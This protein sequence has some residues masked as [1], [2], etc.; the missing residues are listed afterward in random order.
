MAVAG[1]DGLE[2][3]GDRL[4]LVAARAIVG[5]ELVGHSWQYAPCR[6]R[7][8]APRCAISCSRDSG[9][10]SYEIEALPGRRVAALVFVPSA[11]SADTFYVANFGINTIT[12]YD[13]NGERLAVHERIRQWP[14]RPRARL[15]WKPLCLHEQQRDPR[16][17]RRT[18]PIWAFSPAP[19]STM[20]MAWPSIPAAIFS[21][22]TSAGT[23]WKSLRRTGPTWA[24]SRYVIRPTGIAFDARAIST[25]PIFGNTI[26]RFY[27]NGIPLTSSP[28]ST[29][30][31]PEGLAFDSLGN[32]YVANSGSE[33]DPKVFSPAAP[34]RHD[35]QRQS[36]GP[37][38]LAFDTNEN[39]YAVNSTHC[40]DRK[41]HSRRHR[42][43]FA[44]TGFTPTFI[45][46]QRITDRGQYF[47]PAQ[48]LDRRQCARCGIHH[49][50]L[51]HE[52]GLIRGLG[53]SLSGS[54][55]EGA[56]ADPIIELHSDDTGNIML[57]TTTGKTTSE[58][59]IEAT[60]LRR[61]TIRSRDRHD[62][63][64]GV[65]T[66]IERGKAETTG[67]GLIEV[68]DLEAG[69]ARSWQISARADLSTRTLT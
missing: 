58:S 5:F 29:S 56:L 50:W 44:Y 34:T 31:I 55:V 33:L 65:Y 10:L 3:F 49:P 9:H 32:L 63:R 47:D 69:S 61:R 13:A 30:T 52:A 60:G 39:L 28:A 62:T 36:S 46:V 14:L 38:G 54:G 26:A 27:P 2:Q 17:S 24:S 66:V 45:A 16:N 37:I 59:E 11:A 15:E 41:V 64:T 67:V 48:R 42:T 57:P 21:W 20:P 8:N 4:G 7:H 18:G 51:W 43:I 53:P 68:Y 40:D 19:G 23:R 1:L 6:N 25:S 12:K 22:R 35:R